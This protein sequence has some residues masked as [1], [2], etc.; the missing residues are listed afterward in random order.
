MQM[1]DFELDGEYVELNQLLKLIGLVDSGGAGKALVAS[2]AVRVD[3]AVE[4]RKTCK[5]R[6]GQVVALDDIEIHVRA[7]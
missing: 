3:G 4:L 5:I 7:S 2:G 6:D 1:L